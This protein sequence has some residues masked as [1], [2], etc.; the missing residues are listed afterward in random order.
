MTSRHA[1]L[2][3]AAFLLLFSTSLTQERDTASFA[4][5]RLLPGIPVIPRLTASDE[6]PRT[7]IRKTFGSSRMKLDVGAAYDLLEWRPGADS[8]RTFRAG[9]EFFAYALSNNAYGLR[10][11]VDAADGYFGGHFLYTDRTASRLTALRFRILH[12]SSHFLDGHLSAGGGHWRDNR[13]PIPFSRDYGELT[14][15]WRSTTERGHV[16][17]YG[18]TSYATLS[19]PDQLR[20]WVFLAGGEYVDRPSHCYAAVHWTLTGIPAWIG[21]THVESGVRFGSWDESGL[22]IYLSYQTGLVP[23]HQYFD[24]REETWGGGFALDLW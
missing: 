19:R 24:V 11:Q 10:L 4:P 7:G 15:L 5:V 20:R 1:T 21:T 13:D 16:Q 23:F 22:R 6:E 18:G 8:T 17:L 9:V 12:L 2:C 3:G 14:A